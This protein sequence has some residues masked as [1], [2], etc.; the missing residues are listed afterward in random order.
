MNRNA[1]QAQ[2]ILN[3]IKMIRGKWKSDR[4]RWITIFSTTGACV[5]EQYRLVCLTPPV[6]LF[7][8]GHFAGVVWVQLSPSRDRSLQKVVL[9]DRIS[10]LLGLV[11]PRMT[12]LPST[13][14]KGSLNGLM[15]MKMMWIICYDLHSHHF[16][17]CQT[18]TPSS[19]HQMSECLLE[20]FHVSSRDSP[21][22][23]CFEAVC[24]GTQWP[25]TLVEHFLL[26]FSFN[27]LLVYIIH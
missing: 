27:L 13:G 15:N 7:C 1:E 9:S 11:S 10:I 4:V 21:A 20:V 18:A 23:R 25:N 8:W 17:T 22:Q 5:A 3:F 26:F 16:S 24:A 2:L 6:A 14:S 19:E 12:K